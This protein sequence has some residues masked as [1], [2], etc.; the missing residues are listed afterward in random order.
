GSSTSLSSVSGVVFF[1]SSRRRHTR[2][3]RDWSSDVCSSDLV[4][5]LCL[6]GTG[7]AAGRTRARRRLAQPVPSLYTCTTLFNGALTTPCARSEER[8]VGKEGRTRV[9]ADDDVYNGIKRQDRH[10]GQIRRA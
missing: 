6:S 2:F 9:E 7:C 1:F 4:A 8:R 5:A 3:S 10:Q